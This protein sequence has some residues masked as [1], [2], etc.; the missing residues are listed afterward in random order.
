MISRRRTIFLPGLLLAGQQETSVT[1]LSIKNALCAQPDRPASWRAV[2]AQGGD[3]GPANIAPIGGS[4]FFGMGRASIG[5][6]AIAMTGDRESAAC[7]A[8]ALSPP[9][10]FAHQHARRLG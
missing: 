8:L 3:G 6:A 7:G 5:S 10:A 4:R 2:Q 9:D 1:K